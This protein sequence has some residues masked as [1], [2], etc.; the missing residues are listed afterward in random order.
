MIYPQLVGIFGGKSGTRE[1]GIWVAE[2][3]DELIKPRKLGSFRCWQW[4]SVL[5]EGTPKL[6]KHTK[7]IGFFSNYVFVVDRA[8]VLSSKCLSLF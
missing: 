6:P 2:N 8:M 5:K 3:S 4:C 1:I 7:W